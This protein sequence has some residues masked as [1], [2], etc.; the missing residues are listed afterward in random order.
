MAMNTKARGRL[1]VKI[2]APSTVR[3]TDDRVVHN[4]APL[5]TIYVEDPE[6]LRRAKAIIQKIGEHESEL[7]PILAPAIFAVPESWA[8]VVKEIENVRVALGRL[9]KAAVGLLSRAMSA[10]EN[11][12]RRSLWGKW[13]GVSRA[14]TILT[15]VDIALAAAQEQIRP[16]P[17]PSQEAERFALHLAELC[18][19]SGHQ[20]PTG[21]PSDPPR[22][23]YHQLVRD[24]FAAW[25]FGGWKHHAR[26]AA[27][28]VAKDFTGSRER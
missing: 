2:D 16:G 7:V 10:A 25:G 24:A 3:L 11:S 27:R 1:R 20:P 4:T 14:E 12:P 8:A 17:Q 19:R 18:A 23:I 13:R 5:T 26:K 22:H 6:A 15:A 21:E 28:A 9:S